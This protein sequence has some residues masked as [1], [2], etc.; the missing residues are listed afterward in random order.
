MNKKTMVF[1]HK[2]LVSS[3]LEET[4]PLCKRE[5]AL[6]D[7]TQLSRNIAI[8]VKVGRRT[9]ACKARYFILLES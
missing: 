6:C 1:I 8:L 4:V 3:F 9:R 5:W 7:T 2:W